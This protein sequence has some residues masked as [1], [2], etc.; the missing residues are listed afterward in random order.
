MFGVLHVAII[1][2]RKWVIVMEYVQNNYDMNSVMKKVFVMKYSPKI[3]CKQIDKRMLSSF[4][5]V[6]CGNYHY[7]YAQ[8]D[9]YVKSGDTIYLPK[10][11]CYTYEVLSQET[12]VIQV[13]FDLEECSPLHTHTVTFAENPTLIY[14]YS[15]ELC[16]LF[17][18][19][20]DTYYKDKIASISLVSSL[21]L[22]LSISSFVSS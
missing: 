6:I 21:S 13:E 7:K 17:Q 8:S 16:Q 18:Q 15:H 1:Y 14:G 20:F 11:A 3:L 4:L 22:N 10:G 12:Q 2:N 5:Y 19:L 9:I